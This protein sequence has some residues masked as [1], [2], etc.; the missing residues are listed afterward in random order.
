M[1]KGPALYVHVPFCVRK[2]Y[3]CDFA[4]QPYSSSAAM[5]Y[6]Y[7]L[8]QEA[9][10]F[11]TSWP[12][13]QEVSS[14]YVGGGTPTV[15]VSEEL[16]QVL[17]VASAFPRASTIEWTVE[18]NPGTLTLDKLR[19]LK[20]AGVN[21]LSLGVQSFDD[22]IL[23]FLGRTH[24]G[25]EAK[26]A[27]YNARQVGFDNLSLDLI[28]AVPGHSL[29]S[30]R[31]TLKE[32]LALAPEHISTYSLMI[33]EGT[34]F[35][36]RGLTPVS[37]ELDLAQYEE[38]QAVLQKD[39]LCQYEISNFACP[40]FSC[41]HNLVYWY[42]EPYLGLGPSATSYLAGERR[43]NVRNVSEYVQCL[44]E[45][46][47]PVADRELAMPELARAETVILSLRLREGLSRRRFRER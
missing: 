1:S 26:T 3:Y 29:T 43:T 42:N 39:G 7:A 21:R 20:A 44:N 2:C 34:E 47:L 15:L 8:E 31:Q 18:A 41:R 16:E 10:I 33:E 6:L 22:T 5:Q 4:S 37:Q 14:I 13:G 38:A 28:Y 9:Q 25:A 36:R 19:V 17:A 45:G 24:T 40:G 32:A 27:W 11:L 23:T 46:R 35:G 12:R 30:W